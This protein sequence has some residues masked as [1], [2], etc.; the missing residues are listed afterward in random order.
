MTTLSSLADEANRR[1]GNKEGLHLATSIAT[2]LESLQSLPEIVQQMSD[3]LQKQQKPT[4]EMMAKVQ[5]QQK[6]TEEMMAKVQKQQKLKEETMAK[7][8]PYFSNVKA[9]R[10]AI[11]ESRVGRS[12][13]T[14]LIGQRNSI[15]HGGDVRTDV[16]VITEIEP[17]SRDMAERWKLSFEG[18]YFNK[19]EV[20]RDVLP[21]MPEEI[22]SIL[23]IVGNTVL[24]KNMEGK[25]PVRHDVRMEIRE[26]GRAVIAE[27][28]S[29]R[30]FINALEHKCSR[31]ET[32]YRTKWS[33]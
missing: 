18:V 26:K 29:S 5:K 33:W 20:I 28:L 17:D 25:K 32:A 7:L 19:F 16:E 21:V 27:W 2:I 1:C 9:L 22:V 13:S 24:H 14:N 11:L 15:T 10:R 31:L 23:N 12:T 4:E 30:T 8:Q 3:K 6:P